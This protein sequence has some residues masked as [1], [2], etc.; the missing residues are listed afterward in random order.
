MTHKTTVNNN[1]S[2]QTR[3]AVNA[4]QDT[5]FEAFVSDEL[6]SQTAFEKLKSERRKVEDAIAQVNKNIASARRGLQTNQRISSPFSA[7]E[8]K[9]LSLVKQ[10]RE[11]ETE[12]QKERERR[13]RI[14]ESAKRDLASRGDLYLGF[15][16]M[17]AAKAI[18]PVSAYDRVKDAALAEYSALRTEIR[19]R[20][21][22]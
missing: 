5:S 13:R 15:Y 22:K 7:W 14:D 4:Q 6:S 1:N 17:V 21:R 11:L 3:S 16:F 8:T 2:R 18:L 9:R 12:T 20:L 10:L 19:E